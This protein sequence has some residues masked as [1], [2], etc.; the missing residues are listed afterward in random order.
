MH[1]EKELRQ[2]ITLYNLKALES[3]FERFFFKLLFQET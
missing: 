1:K 3:K 2:K